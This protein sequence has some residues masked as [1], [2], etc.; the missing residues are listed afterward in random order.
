MEEL[1]SV[2]KDVGPT[3]KVIFAD[4]LPQVPA[5]GER[6][7]PTFIEIIGKDHPIIR[8]VGIGLAVMILYIL[9]ILFKPRKD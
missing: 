4:I 7:L 3:V 5:M 6:A 9:F 1:L 8:I 2:L